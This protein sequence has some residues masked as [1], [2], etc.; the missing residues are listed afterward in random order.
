MEYSRSLDDYES[1]RIYGVW[2]RHLSFDL[3]ILPPANTAKNLML[4]CGRHP[5]TANTYLHYR[6]VWQCL[7]NTK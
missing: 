7:Q 1:S 2:Q 4:V 6:K 5:C 3:N